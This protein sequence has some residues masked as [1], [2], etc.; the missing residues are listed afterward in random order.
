LEVAF[1]VVLQSK[2]EGKEERE[3]QEIKHKDTWQKKGS[4]KLHIPLPLEKAK[5]PG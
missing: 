3:E 5:R 2:K 4:N 1:V